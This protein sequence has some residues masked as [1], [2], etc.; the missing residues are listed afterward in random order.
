MINFDK[1]INYNR[2]YNENQYLEQ[3]LEL[4]DKKLEEILR[5]HIRSPNNINILQS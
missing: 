4:Y 5:S 2:E 1:Y 3:S